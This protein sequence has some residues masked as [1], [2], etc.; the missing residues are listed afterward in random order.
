MQTL[1]RREGL[2]AREILRSY[3]MSLEARIRMM[4]SFSLYFRRPPLLFSFHRL[5]LPSILSYDY[6]IALIFTVIVDK[7]GGKHFSC[8]AIQVL[9]RNKNTGQN[10]ENCLQGCGGSLI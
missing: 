9:L 10:L 4:L 2:E 3:W 6:V 5:T 8:T 1:D 7:P